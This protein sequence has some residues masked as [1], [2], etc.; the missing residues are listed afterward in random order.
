MHGFV[1]L[2]SQIF[3]RLDSFSTTVLQARAGTCTRS[4]A[5]PCTIGYRLVFAL[6]QTKNSPFFKL[7]QGISLLLTRL[8]RRRLSIVRSCYTKWQDYLFEHTRIVI[9]K[10]SSS[11]P[12][13]L[14]D[15]ISAALSESRMIAGTPKSARTDT[16][17]PR[18]PL[19]AD[20][21]RP[22]TPQTSPVIFPRDGS[23]VLSN[24]NMV[25]GSG[26][27][28][29]RQGAIAAS[30]RHTRRALQYSF[31]GWRHGVQQP[32]RRSAIRLNAGIPHVES[33]PSFPN[34]STLRT[35][36]ASGNY[37][38]GWDIES[39]SRSRSSSPRGSGH[40][41]RG[42]SNTPIVSPVR[43]AGGVLKGVGGRRTETQSLRGGMLF[44]Q[45]RMTEVRLC[46]HT[47]RS[48][49]TG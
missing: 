33:L 43:M 32:L 29:F 30:E 9:T 48:A 23:G 16:L 46:V 5:C 1:P 31:K 26:K 7:C 18:V 39:V 49:V 44:E 28:V 14:T 34:L 22:S 41:S 37:T 17:S 3:R 45:E 25:L 15:L 6:P 47:A 20:L 13:E 21:Q 24:S 38:L 27:V 11:S 8:A 19:N 10:P 36:P 35:P 12:T 42:G 40:D 2:A 4:P